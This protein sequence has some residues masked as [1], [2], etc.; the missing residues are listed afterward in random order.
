MQLGRQLL[1]PKRSSAIDQH[2]DHPHTALQR[3]LDLE[4]HEVIRVVEPTASLLIGK[5]YP[6]APDQGH[7][8]CAG[9]NCLPDDL[10][11]VQACL[12]GVQVHEDA[13]VRETLTQL[14]LQQARV[15]RGVLTP[16]TQEDPRDDTTA[17]PTSP[18]GHHCKRSHEGGM[19][20]SR[21]LALLRQAQPPVSMSR[22]IRPITTVL[23]GR[24]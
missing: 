7:Q 23:S 19:D 22:R 21:Y 15:G 1:L 4:P 12:D 9:V 8:H 3:R 10:G 18:G 16:V 24:G 20:T 14:E 5:G 11:E 6:L 13:H 17:V 2:R